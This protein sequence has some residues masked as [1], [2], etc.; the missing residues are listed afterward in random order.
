[1]R[2]TA[3][4]RQGGVGRSGALSRLPNPVGSRGPRPTAHRP[5]LALLGRLVHPGRC[6]GCKRSAPPVSSS[7]YDRPLPDFRCPV[8][9]AVAAATEGTRTGAR[10][11]SASRCLR[12]QFSRALTKPRSY[13]GKRVVATSFC[14]SP[15]ELLRVGRELRRAVPAWC[16]SVSGC[17]VRPIIGRLAAVPD[18]SSDPYPTLI[19]IP[20]SLARAG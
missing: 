7:Q 1:M 5:H 9:A 8:E 10:K 19:L 15:G 6:C 12:A 20:P 4:L 3:C 18:P 17:A 2:G 11:P 14:P 16:G 13:I